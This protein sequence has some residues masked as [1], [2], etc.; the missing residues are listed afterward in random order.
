MT[1]MVDRRARS[2]R[3]LAERLKSLLGGPVY[4]KRPINHTSF[5]GDSFSDVGTST[6]I[7]NTSWSRDIPSNAKAILLQIVGW[8]SGSQETAYFS[9]G[10]TSDYYYALGV[11]GLTGDKRTENQGWVPCTSGDLYYRCDA[12]GADTLDVVMRVWGYWL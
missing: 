12:S 7:E 1:I 9:V 8:D 3:W 10:P 4:F 5:D 6:K 2:I 11:Q